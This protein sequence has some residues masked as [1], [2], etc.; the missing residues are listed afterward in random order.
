MQ[1]FGLNTDPLSVSGLC[2]VHVVKQ[3]LETVQILYSVLFLVGHPVIELVAIPGE[4]KARPYKPTHLNHPVVW[5]ASA[6]YA[7]VE[8]VLKHANALCKEYQLRYSKTHR[9]FWHVVHI[10]EYV[11]KEQ[12]STRM[13]KQINVSEWLDSLPVEKR[14]KWKN[15]TSAKNPPMG[16]IFGVVAIDFEQ[17]KMTDVDVNDWTLVYN[18]Y[19][20]MKESKMKRP[21]KWY[22]DAKRQKC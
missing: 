16:C 2:N 13:P 17:Y 6:C 8:W 19:Y 7:H 10:E 15:I 9:C 22:G 21:M 14:T 5:W 18:T 20:N 12:L 4:P 11:A 3:A 1:I